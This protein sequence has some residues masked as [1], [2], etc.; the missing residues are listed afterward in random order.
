M[1]SSAEACKISCRTEQQPDMQHD[2]VLL[3]IYADADTL[4]LRQ[5]YLWS[6]SDTISLTLMLKRHSRCSWK[7]TKGMMS[8]PSESRLLGIE[9]RRSSKCFQEKGH[10]VATKALHQLQRSW[11]YALYIHS[12]PVPPSPLPV[13]EGWHG[14]IPYWDGAKEDVKCFNLS[15]EDA[16]FQSRRNGG[17]ESRGQLAN[18]RSSGW[19]GT[20]AIELQPTEFCD[21]AHAEFCAEFDIDYMQRR[22][23]K[24]GLICTEFVNFIFLPL[25][26]CVICA[27]QQFPPIYLLMTIS[28]VFTVLGKRTW[29]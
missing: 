6:D 2:T 20:M 29:Q 3:L 19:S 21:S 7:L 18:Q 11:I 24:V 27:I 12:Y 15:K 16:Q 23:C 5:S 1:T 17:G 14:G 13:W 22:I 25:V 9:E 8:L 28:I 10:L 26:W 4:I